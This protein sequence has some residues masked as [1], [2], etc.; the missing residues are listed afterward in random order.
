MARRWRDRWLAL[1]AKE[2]M[3][4]QRLQDAARSGAPATLSLEQVVSCFALACEQPE[5]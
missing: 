3:V 5:V 4:M 2:S 1:S